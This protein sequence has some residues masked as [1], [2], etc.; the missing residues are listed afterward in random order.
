[1]KFSKHSVINKQRAVIV[2]QRNQILIYQDSKSGLSSLPLDQLVRDLEVMDEVQF[3]DILQKSFKQLQISAGTQVVLLLDPSI[4]FV[5]PV[6]MQADAENSSPESGDT[7]ENQ[8]VLEQSH[9][10][11]AEAVRLA[12]T[13]AV[14]F[15]N[16]YST[17]I[18]VGKEKMVVAVNR[19]L[20]EPIVRILETLRAKVTHILPVVGLPAVFSEGVTEVSIQVLLRTLDR[21]KQLN[22]LETS[23]SRE[24]EPIMST[25]MKSKE[26]PRRVY[27]LIGL[28]V[29]LLL[30]FAAVWYWSHQRDLEAQR[31]IDE[32]K[33]IQ[34]Q[35]A[36]VEQVEETAAVSIA[37]AAEIIELSD[38][39]LRIEYEPANAATA[40]AI[41][42]GLTEVGI[43]Q[44]DIVASTTQVP[45]GTLLIQIP[46]NISNTIRTQLL[47]ALDVYNLS[48]VVEEVESNR[49]LGV[50]ILLRV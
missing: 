8:E 49:E 41:A 46:Q 25:T 13:K 35:S 32:Q 47:D 39:R 9:Q 14:P 36:L 30:L 16:A 18:E 50:D 43:S 6:P 26:H 29:L 7:E 31:I 38:V 4:S 28:F 27:T 10:A 15:A 48:V 21:Y 37:P 24:P 5:Q 42:A 17:V 44:S 2:L 11:R 3:P 19:E 33:Q 34:Q 1:M 23:Y 20:Y 12:F 45:V 40:S 22:L